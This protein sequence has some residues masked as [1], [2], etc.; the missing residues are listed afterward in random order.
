M[1][2]SSILYVLTRVVAALILLQTLYFKF[3]GSPESV[4]IFTIAG[5][6][7]WGR[8]IV[9]IFELIAAILLLINI[10]A[11]LGGVLALA[12]MAGALF[13]HLTKLGISVQSDGGYLFILALVVALCSTYVIF[14]NRQQIRVV[15]KKLQ[16]LRIGAPAN[17]KS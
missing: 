10:T 3:S 7:P 8:I 17:S 4:Y 14:K 6:E 15:L 5:V 2:K 12:L 13:F 9:G 1:Q 16:S 11:W